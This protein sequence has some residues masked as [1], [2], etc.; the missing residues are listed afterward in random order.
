MEVG[1]LANEPKRITIELK[2]GDVIHTKWFKDNSKPIKSK[3]NMTQ[4][5]EQEI[6][7]LKKK[8]H[9]SDDEI[10]QWYI[11]RKRQCEKIYIS[12][13]AYKRLKERNGW[14]KH[15]ADR[16]VVKVYKKGIDLRDVPF[17]CSQWAM[18][19]GNNHLNGDIYKIYGDSIFVFDRKTLITVL[20]IPTK[21]MKKL[22][23][24]KKQK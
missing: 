10:K 23:K 14:N 8:R 22:H 16:M 2:N 17:E 21:I 3:V 1:N 24:T 13:H 20:N 11:A 19:I 18:E 5:E 12:N 7:L 15:S 6:E 4:R 9:I